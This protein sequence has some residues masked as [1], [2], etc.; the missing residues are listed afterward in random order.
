MLAEQHSA[1]VIL[2]DGLLKG[3]EVVGRLFKNEE[4][5]VPEVLKSARAMQWG[6]D[7]L[8]PFLKEGEATN[9]GTFLI[10]TVKGDIHDIGK[11][12][13]CMMFE[14]AGFKVID[15]GINVPAEKF[16][17]A[18]K[19]K[20][21][22]ILGLCALLTTTMQEMKKV[23]DTLVEA[24]VRDSVKIMVG[25]APLT[26]RFSDSIGADAYADNAGEG[27]E[28]ARALLNISA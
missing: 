7:E 5:Y 9:K 28:K 6:V 18:V 26:Q 27:V 21:P 12:L 13:V 14:G 23:I 2:N 10:G 17:A 20:K 16:L 25:G 8:K 4:I 3:M 22:Q 19:E 1:S 15:L 11:N 24:G